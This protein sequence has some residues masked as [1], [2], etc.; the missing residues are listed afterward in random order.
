[1]NTK[2]LLLSAYDAR[3]HSLW[4][5]RVVSLSPQIK[6]QQ[7]VL[8]PRNFNWRI[9]SNS[10]HWASNNK[11]DLCA[12]YDF[13]LAT[14]MVDLSSLRGLVPPLSKLP[15]IVYF[16]E[17]QFAYP[18]QQPEEK[19][20]RPAN[21]EPLLV[22]I[23]SALCADKIVFNTNFNKATFIQGAEKFFNRLPDKLPEVVI[24]K[25]ES[26]EV[27]PVPVEIL[28]AKTTSTERSTTLEVLW[29]HRWE[30]DK[31]PELLLAI[32]ERATRQN[33]PIRF[34][35][36][37]EKFR[38]Q[39][40]AFAQIDQLLREH[41]ENLSIEKGSYGFIDSE[42]QYYN[43]LGSCDVVLSTAMHD[44]QGLAIQEACLAGC[45]PL[46]PD[47]LAYPEYL[48]SNFLYHNE[49]ADT[50]KVNFVV[51]RLQELQDLK[52]NN[53]ELPKVDLTGFTAEVLEA[54]YTEL[55]SFY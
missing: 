6:W 49:L 52:Q 14:S 20:K 37:G 19:D 42:Q 32:I 30:Y 33:L 21:I 47:N 46:A 15:T 55:F 44:F 51:Q 22:P 53:R 48:A 35:I 43:L 41:E 24:K 25:L 39:P 27:I 36:V 45:T 12:D 9:R 28:T 38:Q 5:Q 4:R 18:D 50:D 2:A 31:G 16:H 3:S 11:D 1:M 23:Y 34:H 10:L 40:T 13:L 54:T 8:P 17:N 29:N 26:A 7:L